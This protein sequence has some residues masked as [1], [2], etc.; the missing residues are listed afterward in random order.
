MR[1]LT[2]P[3]RS[4][5]A[6]LLC[7]SCAATLPLS[8]DAEAPAPDMPATTQ[9]GGRIEVL[10]PEGSRQCE[11]D[12]GTPIDAARSELE[13]AGVTVYAARTAGDGMNHMQVCGSPTGRLHFFSIDAADAAAAAELGFMPAPGRP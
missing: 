2:V 4:L 10:K 6:G 11:P 8:A 7:M 13:A 1:M 12:S 9:D 5:G 3:R